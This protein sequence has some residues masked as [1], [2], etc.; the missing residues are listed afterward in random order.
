MKCQKVKIPPTS[1]RGYPLRWILCFS[2]IFCLLAVALSLMF[3]SMVRSLWSFFDECGFLEYMGTS[4]VLVCTS[5]L[6]FS[7]KRILFWC[8]QNFTRRHCLKDDL[9]VE[10]YVFILMSSTPVPYY[11]FLSFVSF[12]LLIICIIYSRHLFLHTLVYFRF[13]FYSFSPCFPQMRQIQFN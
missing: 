8:F 10:H 13:Y 6:L 3:T 11:F 1:F 5:P 9:S 4:L 2:E 7:D 12:F